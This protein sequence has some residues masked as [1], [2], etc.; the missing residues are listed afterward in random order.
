MCYVL[1]HV[2][3][4]LVAGNNKESIKQLI[5][6]IGKKFEITNLGG[7][8]HYL[9]IDIERDDNGRF[10]ISQPSYIDSMTNKHDS[11]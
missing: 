11:K 1:I 5:D 8:S 9:G 10:L 6:S 7:A 2:D 3:D 4:I